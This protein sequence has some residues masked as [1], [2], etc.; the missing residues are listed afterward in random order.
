MGSGCPRTPHPH[1]CVSLWTWQQ[2]PPALLSTI[3]QLGKL[4]GHSPCPFPTGTPAGAGSRL[5][6]S[7]LQLQPSSCLCL[8]AFSG[9]NWLRVRALCPVAW[10]QSLGCS[11]QGKEGKLQAQG[12]EAMNEALFS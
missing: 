3:C 9:V 7:V 6:P 1:S 8:P 5:S 10:Q 4:P 12:C 2:L 11:W